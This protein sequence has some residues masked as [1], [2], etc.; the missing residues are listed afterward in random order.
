MNSLRGRP[1]ES[2]NSDEQLH[3]TATSCEIFFKMNQA[4]CTSET[5][6]LLSICEE[7]E[8]ALAQVE[9][10]SSC[11]IGCHWCCYQDVA[12]SRLEAGAIAAHIDG[13]SRNARA[14]T[15]KR[16]QGYLRRVAD[17]DLVEIWTKRIPCPFLN[18]HNGGCRI[19]KV[20][21]F[22]CRGYSALNSRS[23]KSG[24]PA[25]LTKRCEVYSMLRSA[26][27]SATANGRDLVLESL[28]YAV[29]L[30]L[31]EPTPV[32]FEAQ[33]MFPET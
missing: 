13:L 33:P 23:C 11:K 32:E 2:I 21:P 9:P 10:Q 24:E 28:P 4:R 6:Q 27:A 19:Y 18:E 17:I 15:I 1:A 8:R 14:K 7:V 26:A 12:V 16:M 22:M 29:L 5:E 30:V 25:R 3:R 31:G 20:R